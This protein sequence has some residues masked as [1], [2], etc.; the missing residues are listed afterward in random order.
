M[1]GYRTITVDPLTVN[2]GAVVGGIDFRRLV[3]E[4]QAAEL[5]QAL[6]DHL[7][8]FFHDQ[9]LTEE[10]Q[11]A[12]ASVFGPPVSGSV[13]R[14]PT[15]TGRCSSRLRTLP[16]ARRRPTAGT[17]TS[18]LLR[19]HPNV[20][21]LNMLH[22]AARRRRHAVAQPLRRLRL[23]VAN[24]CRRHF[25]ICNSTCTSARRRRRS[26]SSTVRSTTRG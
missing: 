20:A 22:D 3:D 6:R 13:D 11:L 19:R 25:Q 18:R 16:T 10:Q 9:E 26:A 14:S 5:Q 21:V 7:V 23:T 15:R 24:A 17:L 4:V 8:L 2:I 12:A 1:S